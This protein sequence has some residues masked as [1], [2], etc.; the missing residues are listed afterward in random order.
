M[1]MLKKCDK[2]IIYPTGGVMGIICGQRQVWQVSKPSGK[3]VLYFVRQ[4]EIFIFYTY[5]TLYYLRT[6]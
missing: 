2:I 6:S 1:G 3:C 5:L 4:K